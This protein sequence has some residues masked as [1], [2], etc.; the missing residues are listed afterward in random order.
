MNRI[1]ILSLFCFLRTVVFSQTPAN[2]P[3]WQLKWEDNLT[4]LIQIYESN[5]TKIQCP[6]KI[7]F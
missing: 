7:R 6:S 2:D 3:H 4:L 1:I 5:N